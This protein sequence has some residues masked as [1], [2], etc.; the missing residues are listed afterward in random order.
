[1]EDIDVIENKETEGDIETGEFAEE[2]EEE[3]LSFDDI[4]SFTMLIETA[5]IFICILIFFFFFVL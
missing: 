4:V 5:V 2:T 1:M 3:A